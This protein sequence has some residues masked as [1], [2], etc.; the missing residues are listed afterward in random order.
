M[1]Q[2]DI[3]NVLLVLIISIYTFITKTCQVFNELFPSESGTFLPTK[4]I[5]EPLFYT[6]LSFKI[7]SEIEHARRQ[8]LQIFPSLLYPDPSLLY[9]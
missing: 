6:F 5:E 9:I 7:M 2:K 8:I 3:K 4:I 1:L